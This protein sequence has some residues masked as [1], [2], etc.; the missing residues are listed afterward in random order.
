MYPTLKN[1]ASEAKVSIK[2]VSR[3]VN[4]DPKVSKST[5]KIIQEIIE[6]RG[7]KPNL[8]ARG[9][10]KRKTN[11]IGFI[12]PDIGN[13]SFTEIVKGCTDV[14]NKNDYYVFLSSSEN[15]P[16]KEIEI[17]QDLM[18]MLIE[19]IILVPS[20]TVGRDLSFF[21]KIKCPIVILD[22]EIDGLDKDR[23]I[24]N[25]KKGACS[26]TRLLIENEN[27]KIVILGGL[28]L[29]KTSQ[30]RFEGFKKAMSERNLFSEDL[31]FWGDF[32]IDS[33]YLM[34][35]EA[36]NKFKKDI[37]A[38]FAGNDLIALGAI[39][40]IKEYGLKIPEDIS[41][42]GFDDM[43]FSAYL[44]P[45]L[46]TVHVP[47]NKEGAMAAKMLLKKMANPED[48]NVTRIIIDTNI[49]IRESVK[50]KKNMT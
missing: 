20:I 30:K 7:Y 27:K 37:G 38:V 16:Q 43:F 14:F 28:K 25:N 2:T 6:M 34:M 47:F 22:R 3:V 19:G 35:K 42:I 12:V 5:V 36:F 46:T 48:K 45:P 18:S 9:L 32:S 11:T 21:S 39:N 31:A 23:V 50:N 4:N 13:P 1:I 10:R 15:N 40:A 44:N 49:V 26:A 8:I 41:L 29:A 24:L 17:I 33:G